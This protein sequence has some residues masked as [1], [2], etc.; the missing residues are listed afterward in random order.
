MIGRFMPAVHVLAHRKAADKSHATFLLIFQAQMSDECSPQAGGVSGVILVQMI[1][2]VLH[3]LSSRMAAKHN[4][5][6]KLS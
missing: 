2:F 5:E 4:S 3:L 1:F 6:V